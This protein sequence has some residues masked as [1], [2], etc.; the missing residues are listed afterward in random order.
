VGL[1]A[2][3][4]SRL[5]NSTYYAL[6][7]TRTPLRYALIRV[8]LTLLLGYF[9]ALILPP[10]IGVP[11]RWGVAGLSASAG[12]AAWVEFALLRWRLNQRVGWTGLDRTFLAKLW[13]IALV[14]AGAGFGLKL[15][16]AGLGPRIQG[17]T[18]IPLYGAIYLGG[19][20]M[21][22]MREFDQFV[23][24]VRRQLLGR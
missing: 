18:I 17:L 23:A 16:E 13:A 8:G 3:T 24:Q 4:M 21:L 11:L 14:A 10:L 6:W 7:D 12:V 9:C 2:A 1:L 5:Y 15:I 20:W 22:G 19:T